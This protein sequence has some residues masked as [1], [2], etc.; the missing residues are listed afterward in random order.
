MFVIVASFHPVGKLHMTFACHVHLATKVIACHS[1]LCVLLS[2]VTMAVK[3]MYWCCQA[4]H[5]RL[6]FSHHVGAVPFV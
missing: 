6:Y 4:L 5:P 1:L 2:V 3:R